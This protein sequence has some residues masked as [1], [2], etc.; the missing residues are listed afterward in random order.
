MYYF[1]FEHSSPIFLDSARVGELK[2]LL[3]IR[4]DK[5]VSTRVV[6]PIITYDRILYYDEIMVEIMRLWKLL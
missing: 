2:V 4:I 3:P 1:F 6:P 5:T